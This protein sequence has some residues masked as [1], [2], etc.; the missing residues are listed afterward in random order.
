MMRFLFVGCHNQYLQTHG[1]I[2]STQSE[3]GKESS[4]LVEGG[5]FL[6]QEFEE[7]TKNKLS[8]RN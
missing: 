1:L 6:G 7:R 3:L 8:S 2:I 4:R 5:S